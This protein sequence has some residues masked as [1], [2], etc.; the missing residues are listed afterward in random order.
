M[1]HWIITQG[2]DS[3][4]IQFI[5]NNWLTLSMIGSVVAVLVKLTKSTV[6]DDILAALK[7][8]ASKIRKVQ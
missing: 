7:N 6:D 8:T 5:G 3:A 1:E 2:L 4:L